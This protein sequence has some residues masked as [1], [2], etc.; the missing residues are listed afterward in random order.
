MVCVS[1]S[2]KIFTTIINHHESLTNINHTL[3]KVKPSLI[4][5][6]SS[7]NHKFTITN[8]SLGLLKPLTTMIW[9]KLGRPALKAMMHENA[10]VASVSLS[11]DVNQTVKVGRCRGGAGDWSFHQSSSCF[12]EWRFLRA[13]YELKAV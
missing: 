4:I 7:I 10:Y 5:F 1:T 6:Y 12:G 2:Q 3:T 13:I 11:A 8:P 9:P